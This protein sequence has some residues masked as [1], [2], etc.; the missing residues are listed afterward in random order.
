MAVGASSVVN[1]SLL[2]G[3]LA[4]VTRKPLKEFIQGRH[5]ALSQDI[6]D[7]ADQLRESRTKFE[8]FSAK[9]GAIDSETQTLKK[10]AAKD[11]EQARDRIIGGA[12]E[13]AGVIVADARTGAEGILGDLRVEL[14]QEL[15]LQVVTEAEA[16]LTKHLNDQERVRIRQKISAELGNL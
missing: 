5:K 4:Y 11:A 2:I 8:E 13:T 6:N 3:L 9:L 12:K 10:R 14:R 1:F 15:A 16:S 7:V